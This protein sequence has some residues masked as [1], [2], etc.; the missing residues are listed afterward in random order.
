MP[1]AGAGGAVVLATESQDSAETYI[2]V[3][4]VPDRRDANWRTA[5][6]Q[7]RP[8]AHAVVPPVGQSLPKRRRIQRVA[9]LNRPPE[10]APV[11]H[12]PSPWQMQRHFVRMATF[13]LE[14]SRTTP[15]QRRWRS[16][17][18]SS[19]CSRTSSCSTTAGRGCAAVACRRWTAAPLEPPPASTE[20]R[21]LRPWR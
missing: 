1:S 13:E 7:P 9:A 16:S 17:R 6:L 11:A 21:A 2:G 8:A 3:I 10:P 18:Q 19:D 20:P 12:G 4:S 15:E 14:T 5:V